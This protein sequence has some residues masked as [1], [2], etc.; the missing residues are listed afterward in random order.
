MLFS[1][2]PG[3]G[4]LEPST[5]DAGALDSGAAAAARGDRER[6]SGC[7]AC[8]V[9]KSSAQHLAAN[10][11]AARDPKAH[12]HAT[13]AHTAHALVVGLH[14]VC[15]GGPILLAGIGVAAG[16]GA[17]AGLA[18]TVHDVIHHYEWW[19]VAA[20]GALV[21]LG[22]VFEWRVWRSGVR[23]FPALFALSCL[24]FAV[25]AGIVASHTS[26]HSHAEPAAIVA[27]STPSSADSVAPA[28]AAHDHAGHDHSGHTH[29][30]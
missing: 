11:I 28:P 7:A 5:L 10:E 16:L 25:N 12:G 9:T 23:R 13:R 18:A 19:L 30:H 14:V 22:G 20:S 29:A 3:S 15:C 2:A 17:I 27:P 6:A 24:A 1:N 4:A 8:A 21:A 26:G